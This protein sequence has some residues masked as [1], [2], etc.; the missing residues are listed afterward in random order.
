MKNI[1]KNAKFGDKYID[2][3]G[4]LWLYLSHWNPHN[5]K[6]GMYNLI[7]DNGY[8]MMNNNA[9]DHF[10]PDGTRGFN[11]KYRLRRYEEYI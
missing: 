5:T 11:V 3:N 8:T 7:A 1:F 2:T 6:Q 10:N 4:K 9:I